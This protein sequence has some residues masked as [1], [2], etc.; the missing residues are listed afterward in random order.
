MSSRLWYTILNTVDITQNIMDESANCNHSRKSVD[1]TKT[2]IKFDNPFPNTMAGHIKY[3][4][5]E[6][7]VIIGNNPEWEFVDD[8][9]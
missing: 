8:I 3:T 4:H 6:V 7:L 5:E 1:G 9:S 2:I